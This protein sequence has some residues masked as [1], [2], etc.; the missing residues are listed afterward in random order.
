MQELKITWQRAARIWWLIIWR[1]ALGGAV[2]GAIAGGLIGLM[3]GMSGMSDQTIIFSGRT[4]G[5]VVS[6]AWGLVVVRMALAK[7]YID[8]RLALIPVTLG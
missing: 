3:E 2:F 7:K 5:M 8:F 1:T 4:A 6:L